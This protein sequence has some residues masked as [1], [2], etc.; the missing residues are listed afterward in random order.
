MSVLMVELGDIELRVVVKVVPGMLRWRL[1]VD[2]WALVA[3]LEVGRP[4][5]DAAARAAILRRR[6]WLSARLVTREVERVVVAPGARLPLCGEEITLRV[7]RTFG[8]SSICLRDRELELS[9][10]Y[11]TTPEEVVETLLARWYRKAVRAPFHRVVAQVSREL[12]A[13]PSSVIVTDTKT[14]WGSCTTKGEVRL[15][16]RLALAPAAVLDYVVVHELTHLAHPNHQ[17]LFWREVAAARPAHRDVARW[18]KLYG[19]SLAFSLS[20]WGDFMPD[21]EGGRQALA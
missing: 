1:S 20:G 11:S 10:S 15:S 18:L 8:R 19:P 7:L 5:E 13:S 14:Q 6:R 17:S 21:D 16:W 4:V 2:P 9:L 3:T 12:G